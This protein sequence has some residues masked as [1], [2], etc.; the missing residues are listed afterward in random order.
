MKLSAAIG[1]LCLAGPVLAHA[2]SSL[3][4]EPVEIRTTPQF[5]ADDYLVDNRW[6]VRQRSEAVLR[7]FHAPKKSPKNPLFRGDAGF[8]C[9]SRD[10]QEGLFRMWYQTHARVGKPEEETKTLYA[11][12]YA[13]AKDG[14]N[15][16]RPNLGLHE[17]KG[18]K[19]NNIVWRGPKESR[20]SGH[21]LLDLPESERR[22]HRYVLTYHTSGA[23]KGV[24]GLR[25]IGSPD[26][27]HW[28]ERSDT[29]VHTVPSDTVNS[30]VYDRDRRLYVMYCRAKLTYRLFQ[31]DILDTGESRRIARMSHP[32]LWTEW[33]TVPQNILVPDE[34][35]ARENFNAFY[36]MPARWHA[37]L[38]WGA[39]W[40]FRFND[41]IY[42]E[43]AWSRDGVR[44][45]RLPGRP[46]LIEL[47]PEG[48][49]D[50][51][52]NFASPDWVE[53]GDEWWIYY[54]GWDGDHGSRDRTAGVGLVTLRK[55]G[56]ISLRGPKNGGVVVTRQIRW[57]GGELLVN[58]D[59][60]KGELK[61]RV[62]GDRRK[63]LA[64]FDYVDCE[65][66]RGD[67]T[68]HAIRWKSRSAD[69]LTGQVI[70]LEFFLKDADLF[71]FRA[72]GK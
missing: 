25:V 29:L 66:F 10:P 72:T 61:V 33:P 28:D 4:V 38:Y 15:W 2:A 7:V 30:I 24:N 32:E 64:G 21:Q 56:F 65:V 9:V 63:P 59:A 37:G 36:G 54:S 13:E 55:E 34:F 17:W 31:G 45:D 53:M 46:K 40:C 42:S 23:R 48:A 20:A 60:S 41:N 12:A 50:D 1:W 18:T 6:A 44:F 47:G 52:M 19:A 62:S 70:R 3:P 68:A 5:F 14:L 67:R 8:V 27:I 35:D 58:A 26:G 16:A 22:G 39:L 51:G 57:P 49:W 69:A 71:T 43:L 11:I